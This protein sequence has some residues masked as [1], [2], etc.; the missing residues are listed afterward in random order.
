MSDIHS[1]KRLRPLSPGCRSSACAK[2]STDRSSGNV[3]F[4]R[5]NGA[6]RMAA[7]APMPKSATT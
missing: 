3:Q 6:L 1:F 7:D 2:A 4:A 5:D